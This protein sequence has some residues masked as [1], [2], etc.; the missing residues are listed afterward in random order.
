METSN[1]FSNLRNSQHTGASF[2]LP[3]KSTSEV[4]FFS[5]SIAEF[6]G[7]SEPNEGL[8]R[9]QRTYSDSMLSE[10]IPSWLNELLDEPD[11]PICKSHRRSASDSLA[12]LQFQNSG[13]ESERH[14]VSPQELDATQSD[15][16]EKQNVVDPQ[17]S[18]LQHRCL[19]SN[20]SA[21]RTESKRAKR[22]SAQQQRA[23]KVQYISELERSI[24]ALQEEGYEVSA[25]LEF[26]DQQ[27]LILG[28]ENRALKQRLESLSQEQFIK[29]CE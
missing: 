6:E 8:R 18:F 17:G 22:H 28:M 26:L 24:H 9:H 4:E 1:G 16:F 10:E 19:N 23:R 2:L 11:T 25:E 20:P 12:Y 29:C 7:F 13:E 27:H 5:H 21:S 14:S 15:K 3:P